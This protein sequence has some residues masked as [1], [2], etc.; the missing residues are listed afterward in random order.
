MVMG[1]L[2]F[3]EV[4]CYNSVPILSKISVRPAIMKGCPLRTHKANSWVIPRKRYG[5]LSR[6]SNCIFSLMTSMM[7]FIRSL[8]S[9]CVYLSFFSEYHDQGVW[10]EC[11]GPTEMSS[12]ATSRSYTV[13]KN[14]DVI[15]N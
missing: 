3:R 15:W 12:T 9:A 7:K 1:V 8:Y 6:Y 13:A 4:K 2:S 11:A 10:S 5:V 14:S